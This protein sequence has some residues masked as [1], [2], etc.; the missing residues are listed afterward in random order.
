MRPTGES[1]C[2]KYPYYAIVGKEYGD[3]SGCYRSC[4]TLSEAIN[5][6]LSWLQKNNTDNAK[7]VWNEDSLYK[8]NEHKRAEFNF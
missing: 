4:D 3:W 5:T 8:P 6:V 2:S 1:I 7:V